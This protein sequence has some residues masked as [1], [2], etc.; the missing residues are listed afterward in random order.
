MVEIISIIIGGI[1]A[2]TGIIS[3]IWHI[4]KSRPKLKIDK[5]YF[6]LSRLAKYTDK[7]SSGNMQ[8]IDID[9]QFDNPSLR[10]T[11]IKS[12]W[13]KIGNIHF[14]QKPMIHF[15][16]RPVVLFPG[17]SKSID[18]QLSI[19]EKEFKSLFDK[20]GEITLGIQVFHTF[21]RTKKIERRTKFNTGHF[22]LI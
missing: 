7:T 18:L 5:V 22:N 20:K 6:R 21:G 2:I 9:L 12:I 3:L 14:P 10:S 17:D 19:K 1:V 8:I 16:N 13:I 4:S 15:S 11:T